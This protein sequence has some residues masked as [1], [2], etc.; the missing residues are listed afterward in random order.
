PRI[1]PMH[2]PRVPET[3]EGWSVLHQM[4]RVRWEDWRARPDGERRERAA[5]AAS[6]L[7]ALPRGE[8]GAT[9][10]V[11][12]LGHKGDLMLVHFRRGFEELQG[13]Q[14]AVSRLAV[15]PFLE[16]T[17]SYVS[18]VELGMYEMTAQIHARLRDQGLAAGGD[19]FERA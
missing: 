14:L 8:E 9:A 12:M 5:A 15:A 13:A 4:F 18:V 2:D 7:G 3:L 16:A 10:L 6:T 17:T 1:D 11:T 19:A